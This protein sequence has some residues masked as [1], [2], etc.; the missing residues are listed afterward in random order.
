MSAKD[1]WEDAVQ[2]KIQAG[3]KRDQAIVAVDRATPDLRKNMLLEANRT[4]HAKKDI[5]A[6]FAS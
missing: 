6:R 2:A 4:P 5:E 3:M 1:Q